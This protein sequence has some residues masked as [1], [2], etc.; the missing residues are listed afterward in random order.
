MNQ[1]RITI[2]PDDDGT[3][4][5]F[6]EVSSRGFSGCGSA[7]FDRKWLSEFA[8]QLMQFPLPPGKV[9]EAVGGFWNKR[10]TVTIEQLHL[11]I[12][13]YAVGIKGQV[14]LRVS[15]AT[16]IFDN[17]RAQSQHSAQ[18]E[19]I[20]TYPGLEKFAKQIKLLLDRQITEAILQEE[21]S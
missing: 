2:K 3:C 12:A 21:S 13:A 6:A 9:I 1:L 16:P 19:L 17:D 8:D 11:A 14:G 5:L 7:W 15:V 20:T 18:V 4:E 10:N